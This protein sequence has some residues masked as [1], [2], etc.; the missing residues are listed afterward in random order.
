M[1]HKLTFGQ[2]RGNVRFVPIADMDRIFVGVA[3]T[4]E[5]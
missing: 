2:R 3:W 4:P 5:E 1:G